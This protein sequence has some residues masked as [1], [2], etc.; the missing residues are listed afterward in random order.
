MKVGHK[1][2]AVKIQLGKQADIHGI[3][4]I[5][6][7]EG[8]LGNAILYHCALCLPFPQLWVKSDDAA[9]G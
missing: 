5:K 9:E 8:G 1:N 2:K 4:R 7:N 6:L 3:T